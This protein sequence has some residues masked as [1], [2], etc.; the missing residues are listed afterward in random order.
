MKLIGYLVK[1]L[2]DNNYHVSNKKLD[3]EEFVTVDNR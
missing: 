2:K 3:G 1:I